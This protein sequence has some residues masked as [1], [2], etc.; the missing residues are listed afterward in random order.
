MFYFDF[1]VFWI[2]DKF[3][4]QCYDGYVE[5]LIKLLMNM[6]VGKLQGNLWFWGVIDIYCLVYG[7]Y[8]FVD[9]D[10]NVLIVGIDVYKDYMVVF[11]EVYLDQM[12]SLMEQVL[13]VD[14]NVILEYLNLVGIIYLCQQC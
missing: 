5:W 13:E 7:N 12:F 14:V 2:V 10:G 3:C 4:G 8:M 1:G 9:D 11:I 6:E